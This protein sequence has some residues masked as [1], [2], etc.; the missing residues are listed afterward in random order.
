MRAVLGHC[1]LVA[2]QLACGKFL[3]WDQ[4]QLLALVQEFDV[5]RH[6]VSSEVYTTAAQFVESSTTSSNYDPVKQ[7]RAFVEASDTYRH[8]CIYEEYLAEEF[9]DRDDYEE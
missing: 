6:L 9:G 2:G 3:G 8:W 1:K 7:Q 4:V 5:I